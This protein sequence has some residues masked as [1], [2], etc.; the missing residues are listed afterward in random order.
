MNVFAFYNLNKVKQINLYICKPKNSLWYVVVHCLVTKSCPT[1]F[2]SMH[3]SVPGFPVFH[4]LPELAQTH[5]HWVSDAIP[6]SYPLLPPAPALKLSQHQGLFQR[7]IS[8]HQVT[9]TSSFS[10]S[11]SSEYSGLISFGS[12]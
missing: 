9:K 1:L 5:V 7:V 12:Y 11:P 8:L 3:W 6:T 10:I 2:D 4:C